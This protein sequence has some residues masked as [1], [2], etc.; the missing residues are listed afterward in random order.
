MSGSKVVTV[1]LLDL[2][3]PLAAPA[4]PYL[5]YYTGKAAFSAGK[6]IVKGA[7]TTIDL[8]AKGIERYCEYIRKNFAKQ[9]W[10]KRVKRRA[11]CSVKTSILHRRSVNRF[12]RN[13]L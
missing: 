8:A 13:R 1:T 7:N 4:L 2:L 3:I 10:N 12:V 9:N 6:G 11:T 5:T